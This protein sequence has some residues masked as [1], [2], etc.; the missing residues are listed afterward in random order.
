MKCTLISNRGL[1]YFCLQNFLNFKR[2]LVEVNILMLRSDVLWQNHHQYTTTNPASKS[3]IK[4]LK[5]IV[6]KIRNNAAK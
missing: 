4:I 2:I 5:I 3:K 6:G 1:Q